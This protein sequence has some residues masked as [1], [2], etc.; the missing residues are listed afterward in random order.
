[1]KL[2]TC[3]F[4]GEHQ[5]EV[6][7]LTDGVTKEIQGYAVQCGY[8]DA[9]SGECGKP[10]SAQS[11]WNKRAIDKTVINNLLKCNSPLD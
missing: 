7:E 10:E 6:L 11:E 8:C 2:K 3:P 4:C 1:M 5:Q 9:R